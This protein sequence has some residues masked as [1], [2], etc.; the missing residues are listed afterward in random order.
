MNLLTTPEPS[1][2]AAA[3]LLVLLAGAFALRGA[4]R[5]VQ[6]AAVGGHI[7]VLARCP[8]NAKCGVALL[9]VEGQKLLLGVSDERVALVATLADAAP[10][11]AP[12]EA[13]LLGRVE[14]PQQASDLRQGAAA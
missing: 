10:S 13:G 12:L 1:L 8:L 2:V 5:K 14:A 4:L 3:S 9:E 11:G 6:L 7:R